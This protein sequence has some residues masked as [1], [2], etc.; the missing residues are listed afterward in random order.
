MADVVMPQMGESIVEGTLTKWLKKEGDKVKP[1]DIVVLD[2]VGAHKAAEVKRLIRAAGARVPFLR[3]TRPTWIPS[4]S[5]G[6]S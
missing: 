1:G 4:S 6:A 3:R 5:A 2:D